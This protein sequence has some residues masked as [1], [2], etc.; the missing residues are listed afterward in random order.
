[1]TEPTVPA[2]EPRPQTEGGRIDRA[3]TGI[4]IALT[5][6]FVVVA[7]VVELLLAV[8]IIFELGFTLV[9]QRPPRHKIRD[10]ANQV[11]TYV[12]RV[13]R[14]LTYNEAAPPFPFTDFPEALE[15]PTD[16]YDE[17]GAASATAAE[18]RSST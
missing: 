6:L 14:Y 8:L 4:R 9:T 13:T 17:A 11:C 10:F 16:Q 18:P 12:Y 1:M 15:P 3:A 5:L 2:S 7:R